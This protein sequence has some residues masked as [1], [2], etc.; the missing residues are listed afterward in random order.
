MC[1]EGSELPTVHAVN[2]NVD[3]VEC[4]PKQLGRDSYAWPAPGWEARQHHQRAGGV[5]SRA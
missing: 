1:P 2:V 3:G 5:R 4:L